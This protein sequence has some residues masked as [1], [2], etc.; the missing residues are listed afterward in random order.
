MIAINKII[1]CKIC[2]RSFEYKAKIRRVYCS[3][4]CSQ[5]G[6]RL[7]VQHWYQSHFDVGLCVRCSLPAKLGRVKCTKCL[8]IATTRGP[9]RNEN[10]KCRIC[11]QPKLA[12]IQLC[13]SCKNKDSARSKRRRLFLQSNGLC[14]DCGKE[15]LQAAYKTCYRCRTKRQLQKKR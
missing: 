8:F 12:S 6:K 15:L 14:G 2:L 11:F 1:L 10:K 3:S 13:L 7:Q 4:Y 9:D 5:I